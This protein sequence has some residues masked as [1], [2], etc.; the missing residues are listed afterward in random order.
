[1]ISDADGRINNVFGTGAYPSAPLSSY[2]QFQRAAP[3]RQA[4]IALKVVFRNFQ[5]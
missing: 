5:G 3:P 4:Q 1:V 2:G